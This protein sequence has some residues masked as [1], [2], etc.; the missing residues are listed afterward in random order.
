LFDKSEDLQ[1]QLKDIGS[2]ERISNQIV[3]SVLSNVAFSMRFE[4]GKTSGEAESDYG[5]KAGG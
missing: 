4:T 5:N 1:T 2:E 3:L